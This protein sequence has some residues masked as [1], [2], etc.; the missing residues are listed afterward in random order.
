MK[1]L[2]IISDS[3]KLLDA[4]QRR[5]KFTGSP[6]LEIICSSLCDGFNVF[7]EQD[8]AFIL[9]HEHEINQNC[10]TGSEVFRDIKS[11]ISSK[12]ELF[13]LVLSDDNSSNSIPLNTSMEE[14][15]KK[16]GL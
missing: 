10:V 14:I 6:T 16:F 12:Q 2:L 3:E 5:F 1:K 13:I 7:L 9:M 11:T 15:I 8:P 4:W